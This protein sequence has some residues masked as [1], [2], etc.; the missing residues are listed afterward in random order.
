MALTLTT[1]RIAG[2]RRE[3][4]GGLGTEEFDQWAPEVTRVTQPGLTLRGD[5]NTSTQQNVSPE[6]D[7]KSDPSFIFMNSL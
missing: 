1:A 6:K 2:E 3:G 4:G 5:K 7:L